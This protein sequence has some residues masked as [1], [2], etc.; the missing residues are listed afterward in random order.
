MPPSISIYVYIYTNKCN[1]CIYF[2]NPQSLHYYVGPSKWPTVR[3]RAFAVRSRNFLGNFSSVRGRLHTIRLQIIQCT[4]MIAFLRWK[5]LY[6]L[7]SHKSTQSCAIVALT[8]R[9]C[10]SLGGQQRNAP[11]KRSSASSTSGTPGST[12]PL[13]C[14]ILARSNG[15]F[16][17]H[18]GSARPQWCR[19]FCVPLRYC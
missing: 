6:C 10:G 9:G 1:I 5:R 15:A 2:W 3:S 11:S 17:C 19:R 4:K 7:H 8:G 12:S 18:Q 14:D 16:W 13:W